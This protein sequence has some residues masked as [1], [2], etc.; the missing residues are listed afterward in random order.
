MQQGEIHRERLSTDELGRIRREL[1]FKR[2]ED[3]TPS[4]SHSRSS[5]GR[6][7]KIAIP[8]WSLSSDLLL[9]FYLCHPVNF[10]TRDFL[11]TNNSEYF[12]NAVSFKTHP[13]NTVPR[14][15]RGYPAIRG[16]VGCSC[17]GNLRPA[18]I[19][20]RTSSRRMPARVVIATPTDN[21]HAQ[22]ES[23][24]QGDREAD[25]NSGPLVQPGNGSRTPTR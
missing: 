18:R 24:R 19:H 4:H 11:I 20:L 14:G 16:D 1:A 12:T 10:V 17:N 7:K 8:A 23:S 2:G 22:T 21:L 5:P 9:F 15:Y 6:G 3:E 25:V 13:I